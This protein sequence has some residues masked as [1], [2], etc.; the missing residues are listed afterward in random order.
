MILDYLLAEEGSVCGKLNV[1]NCY[2][3]IDGNGEGVKQITSETGKLAHVPVRTWKD[4]NIDLF[5]WLLGSPWVKRILF[6]YVV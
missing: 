1:S 5:S 2:L 3:K 4:W 6:S